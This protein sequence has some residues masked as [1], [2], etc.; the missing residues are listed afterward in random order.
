[1][2]AILLTIAGLLVLTGLIWMGQGLGY[3]KGSF[4][5]GD[6]RW[7]WIGLA[8]SSTGLLLAAATRIQRI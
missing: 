7:F 1:M 8:A 6:M 2:R 4:M 5:T 3:V